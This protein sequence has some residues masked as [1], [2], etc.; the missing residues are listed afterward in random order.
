MERVYETDRMARLGGYLG[1]FLICFLFLL[2]HSEMTGAT[3]ALTDFHI[4]LWALFPFAVAGILTWS[5]DNPKFVDLKSLAIQW[6]VSLVVLLYGQLDLQV[7]QLQLNMFEALGGNPLLFAALLSFIYSAIGALGLFLFLKKDNRSV[8]LLA[9]F[10][11][12]WAI[13]ATMI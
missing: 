1:L 4:Y 11:I 10:A 3:V 7:L 13:I 8:I 5:F 6:A 12:I 9:N 2:V